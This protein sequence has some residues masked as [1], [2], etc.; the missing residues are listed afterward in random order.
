MSVKI[1]AEAFGKVKVFSEA[2]GP[3]NLVK[4]LP[5]PPL[6]EPKMPATSAVARSTASV[7]LPDPLKIEAVRVSE[8]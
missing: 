8:I 7:V 4:P 1:V 5:V 2:A 3:E 6:A